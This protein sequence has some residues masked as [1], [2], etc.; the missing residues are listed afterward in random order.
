MTSPVAM[1]NA[2]NRLLTRGGCSHGRAVPGC[3]APLVTTAGIGPK[4]ALGTFR[5][6]TAPLPSPAGCGKGRRRR[7]LGHEQRVGRQFEP[8]LERRLGLEFPPDPPDGRWRQTGPMRHR[9]P[10]PVGG[11]GRRLLQRGSDDLLDPVRRIDDALDRVAQTWH[12]ENRNSPNQIGIS[13]AMSI[14]V[15]VTTTKEGAAALEAAAIEAVRLGV[16]L[17][18]VN[19]TA[20]DLDTSPIAQ[21]VHYEV[22]VPHGPTVLDEVEEVLKCLRTTRRSPCS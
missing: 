5:R 1:L 20:S 4:P 8:D 21:E 18:A 6:C 13:Q 15:A 12:R 11:I 9:H 14:C 17:V 2:A 10:R 19:L 16:Q 3:R 7:R 22:V